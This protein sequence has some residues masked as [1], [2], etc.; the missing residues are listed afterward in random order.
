M[1]KGMAEERKTE[2]FWDLFVHC[3]YSFLFQEATSQN[4]TGLTSREREFCELFTE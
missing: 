3:L 1:A 2:I 4:V